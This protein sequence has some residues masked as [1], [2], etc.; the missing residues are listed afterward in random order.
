MALVLF[1]NRSCDVLVSL[2]LLKLLISSH[3]CVCV[4]VGEGGGGGERGRKDRARL[5]HKLLD[6][7]R[8][9]D[10]PK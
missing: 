4:C 6:C 8:A 2:N 10:N 5:V 3:V 7:R 1:G 9:F